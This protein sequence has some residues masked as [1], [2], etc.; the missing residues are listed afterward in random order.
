MI[1]FVD[2]IEVGNGNLTS[3]DNDMARE[4]SENLGLPGTGG[5]DA[6]RIDDVGKWL[7]V[8]EKEIQDENQLVEELHAGRFRPVQD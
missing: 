5:S 8:F 1:E 4:V 7:T 3:D 6:H 2:A